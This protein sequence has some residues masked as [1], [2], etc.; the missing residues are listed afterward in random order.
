M[1]IVTAYLVKT[2]Y[3]KCLFLST[4][5]KTCLKLLTRTQIN[6]RCSI[7]QDVNKV[8]HRNQL[9]QQL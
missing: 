3:H 4:C 2:A 1:N 9:I 5:D 7:I 6:A 8:K